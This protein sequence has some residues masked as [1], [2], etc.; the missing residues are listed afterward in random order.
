MRSEDGK[1][2]SRVNPSDEMKV[3]I[4][5]MYFGQAKDTRK[6]KVPCIFYIESAETT[7]KNLKLNICNNIINAYLL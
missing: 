1:F 4:Q 5:K 6:V 7:R 2:P 3:T